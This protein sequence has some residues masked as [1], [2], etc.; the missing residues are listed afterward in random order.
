MM[1]SYTGINIQWPISQLIMSGQKTVETR[2]YPI[3]KKYIGQLMLVIETPGK[4]NS[5]S[6][7]ICGIIVFDESFKYSSKKHFE[8][9]IGRHFV[10]SDSPWAWNKKEKWGW[11]ILS[12]QLFEKYKPAPPKKGIK[13][14]TNIRIDSKQ[15]F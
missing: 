9:D 13:F 1:K 4:S 2:T 12:V 8:S 15:L 7:R 11:P 14:T 5:F 3:P 10:E 6:A